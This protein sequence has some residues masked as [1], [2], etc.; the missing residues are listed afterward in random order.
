MK[1]NNTLLALALLGLSGCIGSEIGIDDTRLA[2]VVRIMPA[3]EPVVD[4]RDD[5]A[6]TNDEYSVAYD[7]GVLSWRYQEVQGTFREDINP[8]M[9]DIDWF[10]FKPVGDGNFRIELYFGGSVSTMAAPGG[11]GGGGDGGPPG[12]GGGL[13]DTGG[14]PGRWRRHRHRRPPGRRRGSPRRRHRSR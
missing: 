6:S 5:S 7:L 14:P 13:P 2:G 12:D 10:K 4:D 9:G 11:G 3:S 8:L 1:T